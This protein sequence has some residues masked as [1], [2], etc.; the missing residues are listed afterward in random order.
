MNVILNHGR[1]EGYPNDVPDE[2]VMLIK[3]VKVYQKL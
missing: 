2:S 3:N 1:H